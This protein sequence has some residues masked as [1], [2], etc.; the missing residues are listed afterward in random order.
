MI[1]TEQISTNRYA[2]SGADAVNLYGTSLTNSLTLGQ[3]VIA[4]SIR[5]AAASEA[6]SVIRMNKMTSDSVLLDKAAGW[7]QKVA[8]GTANWSEAKAFCVDTLGIAADTLPADINSYNNRMAAVKAMKLKMD[9]LTQKQQEDMID[10]Q[11]LVN[12]RDVAYSASSN[13]VR[14]LGN[15]MN[16]GAAGL[17]R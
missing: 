13:I 9:A 15:S 16:I 6:Q 1:T 12:R 4:V 2:P 5:S 7:L 3:L 14:A 17:K 11:T 8:D 10:I